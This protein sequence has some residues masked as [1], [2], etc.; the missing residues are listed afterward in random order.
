MTP[1]HFDTIDTVRTQSAGERHAQARTTDD[2]ECPCYSFVFHTYCY[3]IVS[4][5]YTHFSLLLLMPLEL[6]GILVSILVSFPSNPS[7]NGQGDLHKSYPPLL[8][9]LSVALSIKAPIFTTGYEA[10][11]H[12]PH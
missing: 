9:W 8:P 12:L 4:K 2:P 5:T 6:G 1:S 3:S 7:H 10:P 11:H